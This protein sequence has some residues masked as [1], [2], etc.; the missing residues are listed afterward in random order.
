MLVGLFEVQAN[1]MAARSVCTTL[2][3]SL[4]PKGAPSSIFFFISITIDS[5]PPGMDKILVSS[6]GEVCVSNDG[7]T[8]LERMEVENEIAKVLSTF[9]YFYSFYV[10]LMSM[11]SGQLLVELSKSQDQEIGDGTTG[12]VVLAGALLEQ[13]EL[14]LDRGLHPR[15]I[16]DGFEVAC[17]V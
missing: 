7:A 1:I 10:N 3:S 2:R 14:L 5:L 6:D 12:V 11:A 16:S 13:A 17:K 15:R 8:I 9:N 4:G